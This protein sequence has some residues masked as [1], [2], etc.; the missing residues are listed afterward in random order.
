MDLIAGGEAVARGSV[1]RHLAR[2]ARLRPGERVEVSDQVRAYVAVAETCSRHE[3][4]FR[5]DEALPLPDVPPRLEAALA[6]IRFNRFE[7]AVEKLTEIG[8]HRIIPTVADRSDSHLVAAAPKRLD[9]WRRIAFEA[10]QQSRRLTAPDV[11]APSALGEVIGGSV[12]GLTTLMADPGGRPL[13]QVHSGEATRFLVGPEGGWTEAE[14]R[15]A[16][17]SGCASASL[18]ENVLRAETA[19]VAMAAVCAT[20]ARKEL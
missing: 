7:W 10:A 16:S 9:R 3:V 12:A 5:I 4:R 8:V 6:I 20:S 1:A 18:G 2:V 19:A 15:L 11:E 14:Q 17:K 13:L